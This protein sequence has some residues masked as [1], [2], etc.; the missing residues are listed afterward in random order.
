MRGFAAIGM[1]ALAVTAVSAAPLHQR[2]DALIAKAAGDA[3]VAERTTDAEFIRRIYLDFA[4]TIP[5]AGEVRDFLADPQ[6]T[7]LIDRL[8]ADERFPQ[9][10]ADAF[11]VILMERRGTEQEWRQFL[12]DAFAAN[13]PWDEI[14][15]QI[16]NP[17]FKDEQLRGAGYFITQRLTKSGQQPTDYPGL[18]RDVGRLFMGVDLQ[19]AQCHRHLTVKDYRQVEFNGLFNVYQNLKLQRPNKEFKTAWVSENAMEKKYEFVSVFTEKRGETGP[20]IPFGKEIE[21]QKYEGKEKWIVEPTRLNRNAGVPRFSPLREIANGVAHPDNSFFA[22]NLANRV[23]HLMI[24]R[25]LV[26][27]LD[28]MHSKNPPSH[29]ELLDLLE[30]EIVAHKFDLRWLMRELALTK[31]YQRTSR[32]VA[33]VSEGKFTVAKERPVSAEQMLNAF[34]TATGEFDRV[35]NGKQSKDDPGHEELRKAFHA[36]FA[37]APKVPELEVNPGLRGALFLSNSDLVQWSLQ[38]REGNL[39]HQL[40][41]M[42]PTAGIE[43]LYLSVLSRKPAHDETKIAAAYLKKRSANPERAWR[44]LV[45]SLLSSIEFQTNH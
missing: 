33:E 39:I 19:C 43:H 42:D 11:H 5:T 3:P 30:K 18:T 1:F 44:N 12:T 28:L 23:W 31:T 7:E 4:G 6:R 22:R 38:S 8:I 32:L 29:P 9:R 24:G 45:W 16:L 20:R 25:G 13:R 40:T 15:R 14:V 2:V 21:I 34:L 36:A 17:E 26:E 27:P 10:M 35:V 41:S 37:N